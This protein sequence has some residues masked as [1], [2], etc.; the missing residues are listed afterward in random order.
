M[1]LEHVFMKFYEHNLLLVKPSKISKG[2]NTDVIY[3]C[4]LTVLLPSWGMGVSGS[5]GLR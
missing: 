4:G 1:T 3:F 2:V 5:L